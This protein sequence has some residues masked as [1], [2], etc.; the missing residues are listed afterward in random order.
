MVVLFYAWLKPG[1][2]LVLSGLLIEHERAVA[3]RFADIGFTARG[4]LRENNWVSL[5]MEKGAA[6]E[7]PHSD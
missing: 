6:L 4:R 1:G 2:F 3:E 7:E 5:L